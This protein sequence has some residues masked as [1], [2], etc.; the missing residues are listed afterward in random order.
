MSLYF[1]LY[2]SSFEG[3]QT[4]CLV[5]SMGSLPADVL[6]LFCIQQQIQKI[7]KVA[8]YRYHIVTTKKF[9]EAIRGLYHQWYSYL[10]QRALSSM[11]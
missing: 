11:V 5:I 10:R 7:V 9:L 2:T 8:S 3:V 6:Q 1:T 4:M